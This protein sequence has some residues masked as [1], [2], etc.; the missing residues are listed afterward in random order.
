MYIVKTPVRIAFGGGGTDVEPYSSDYGGCVI[1][2]TINIYFRCMLTKRE[3]NLINIYSNDKFLPYKFDTLEILN[4][5]AKISNLFEA[6]FYL[7]KPKSGMDI[8][9]HGEPLKKAGLGA[10]ASLCTCL[11]SGILKIEEKAIDI[12]DISEKAYYVEQNI[13]KNVGGRQDQYASVYGGF[14]RLEFLGDSNVKV[15]KLNISKSFKQEIEENLILF[16]TGE[17]HISGNMVKEQVKLYIKNKETSKTFLDKLKEIAYQM[18]DSL[19]SENFEKFGKLLSEDLKYKTKFNP[20][21]TTDYMKELNRLILNNGGIGGRVCGA[22]GGGCMIWLVKPNLKIKLKN[23]L[24][25]QQGK[26]IEYKFTDMGLEI[27]KV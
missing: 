16:Y 12:D 25:N 18:R 9:V 4:P 14:N 7:M 17:P 21:L 10:S 5:K 27:L 15:E 19:L 22:G 11:I 2:T 23:L 1:N 8:Y 13:I 26:L 20:L 24:L 6:I 3:D